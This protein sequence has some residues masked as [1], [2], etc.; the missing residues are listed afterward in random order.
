VRDRVIGGREDEDWKTGGCRLVDEMKTVGE[1]MMT[2]ERAGGT[3]RL[4]DEDKWKSR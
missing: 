3:G 1:R 2:G 4:V